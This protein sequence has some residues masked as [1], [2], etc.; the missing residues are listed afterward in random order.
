LA[1]WDVKTQKELQAVRLQRDPLGGAF[2]ARG[3]RFAL[4]FGDDVDVLDI[5]SGKLASLDLP[6]GS[7]ATAFFPP[8]SRLIVTVAMVPAREMAE[9]PLSQRVFASGELSIWDAQTGE[10]VRRIEAE[11]PLYAGSISSDGELIVAS[12]RFNSMTVWGVQP[13]R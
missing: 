13:T 7:S 6:K 8:D 12:T 4:N 5:A 2:S 9:R 1:V 10:L 11:E 3:D